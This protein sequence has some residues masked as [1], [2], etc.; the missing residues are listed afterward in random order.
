M[1]CLTM[2]VMVMVMVVVMMEINEEKTVYGA[3]IKQNRTLTFGDLRPNRPP[4]T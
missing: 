3:E 1:A 4:G 2:V